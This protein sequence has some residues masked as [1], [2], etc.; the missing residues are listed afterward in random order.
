MYE[1]A[2]GL[3]PMNPII[4]RILGEKYLKNNQ[5]S[6]AFDSIKNSIKSLADIKEMKK[7]DKEIII[8]E[9]LIAETK[10]FKEL[11]NFFYETLIDIYK[12]FEKFSPNSNIK[13][14]KKIGFS[15]YKIGEEQEALEAFNK[16]IVIL[17]GFSNKRI[18]E[19]EKKGLI[20]IVKNTKF[21]EIYSKIKEITIK[22]EADLINTFDKM[23][24]LERRQALR[25]MADEIK[26]LTEKYKK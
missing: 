2:K 20:D 12:N 3:T 4:H 24:T 21:T 5:G 25:D 8:I 13:I 22:R 9:N 23:T 11:E 19:R 18:L 17:K 16:C 1:K 14:L 10:E 6:E 7:L 15:Y 26:K